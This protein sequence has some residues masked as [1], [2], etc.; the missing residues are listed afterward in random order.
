MPFTITI[1][2]SKLLLP[3]F[4]DIFIPFVVITI[5]SLYVAFSCLN[6]F[7]RE[8]QVFSDKIVII[9]LLGNRIVKPD[10]VIRILPLTPEEAKRYLKKLFVLHFNERI[11]D[12]VLIERKSRW[13]YVLTPLNK[14]ELMER[15]KEAWGEDIVKESQ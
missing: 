1:F 6:L 11:E 9:H 12:S 14:D 8:I 5:T 7:T 13:D 3:P 15:I 2:L 4:Y 10:E